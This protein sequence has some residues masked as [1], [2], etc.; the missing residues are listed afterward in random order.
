MG[1]RDDAVQAGTRAIDLAVRDHNDELIPAL[2]AK[3]ARDRQSR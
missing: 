1:R 3:L 2:R